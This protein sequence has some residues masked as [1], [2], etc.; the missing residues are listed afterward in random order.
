M[1]IFNGIIFSFQR[2]THG[3]KRHKYFQLIAHCSI[4]EWVVLVTLPL[5][6]P[7]FGCTPPRSYTFT[8]TSLWELVISVHLGA[9]FL[10]TLISIKQ[11]LK[12][13]LILIALITS[14][15]KHFPRCLLTRWISLMWIA[16]LN[17]LPTY[18]LGRNLFSLINFNELFMWHSYQ[19]FVY[20]SWCNH[21]FI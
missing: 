8:P 2:L 16:C 20:C 7:E 14:K 10:G 5:R 12:T 4:K 21:L 6:G 1:N 19:P 11:H 18:L 9:M 13:A 3:T 17:V 15:A